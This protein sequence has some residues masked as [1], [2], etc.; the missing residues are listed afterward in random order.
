MSIK[1]KAK[2]IGKAILFKKLYDEFIA[3]K[4]GKGMDIHILIEHVENWKA[5]NPDDLNCVLASILVKAQ[6]ASPEEIKEEV[7]QAK[8]QYTTEDSELIPWFEC[9]IE[10]A[11]SEDKEE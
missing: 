7:N 2:K 8:E 4:E 9:Q 1:S 6:D 5:E 3:K 11:T 10:N